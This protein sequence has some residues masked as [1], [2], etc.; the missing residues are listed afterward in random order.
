MSRTQ[1]TLPSISLDFFSGIALGLYIQL[2]VYH[3]IHYTDL[4]IHKEYK[5]TVLSPTGSKDGAQGWCN[6]VLYVFLSPTIRR[7]LII[8]PCNSF[9]SFLDSAVVKA[10]GFLETN[11]NRIQANVQSERRGLLQAEARQCDAAGGNGHTQSSVNV[12]K[13]V[14]RKEIVTLI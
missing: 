14:G 1:S 5:L 3:S 12:V 6:A 7:R 8:D 2:C 13:M 9:L 4:R 11:N 10:A